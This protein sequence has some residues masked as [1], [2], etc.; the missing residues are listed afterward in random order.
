MS[1]IAI[2][3]N[4]AQNSSFVRSL[5]MI[6]YVCM[7]KITELLTLGKV[8]VIN[9]SVLS[10]LEAPGAK[11]LPRMFPFCAICASLGRL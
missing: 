5:R 10:L 8:V 1:D 9:I 11:T 3:L 2:N 7:Y 4:F 6:I